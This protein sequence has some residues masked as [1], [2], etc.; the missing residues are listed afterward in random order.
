MKITDSDDSFHDDIDD[1]VMDDRR[2][3]AVDSYMRA[4]MRTSDLDCLSNNCSGHTQLGKRVSAEA[5]EL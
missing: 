1:P 2:F 4:Y 3:F 5:A